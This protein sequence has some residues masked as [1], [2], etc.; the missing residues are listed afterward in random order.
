MTKAHRTG[1]ETGQAPLDYYQGLNTKVFDLV[2][3]GSKRILEV[4]CAKGRL[5]AAIKAR[6]QCARYVGIELFEEAGQEAEKRLDKVFVADVERFDWNRLAGET[7][8]CVIFADVLEHLADP[9]PVL[10]QV[11]KLLAPGGSVV[12]CIPNVAHWSVLTGLIRG[13]WTYTETGVMD[14]THLRFFTYPSFQALLKEC[15]LESVVEDRWYTEIEP[16]ESLFPFLHSLQVDPR[17]F[18]NRATT[19]QFII[20]AQPV[21]AK[22]SAPSADW[23]AAGVPVPADQDSVAIVI[24]ACN[25]TKLT[26]ACLDSIAGSGGSGF[27]V[28]VVDDATCDGTEQLIA[29]ARKSQPWLHTLRL[30]KSVGL[31][32]A[33]NRGAEAT[34][35]GTLVFLDG[36]SL[37][38]PGWLAGML[39]LIRKERVGA[40]APKLVHPDGTLSHVG[41]VFTPDA[42]PVFQYRSAPEADPLANRVKEYPALTGACLM[43]KR[44]VFQEIGGFSG[45]DPT[46]YS[47]LDL[48][49]KMRAKGHR[50]LYQPASKVIYAREGNS[51][52][53]RMTENESALARVLFIQ[54]W[55]DVM[56][57]ELQEESRFYASGRDF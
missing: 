45:E 7:F 4:G 57:K 55:K 33:R 16:P 1:P 8:D 51:G 21:G 13:E 35:A 36:N 49:F 41:I 37:V 10:R 47:D 25:L 53:I 54:R 15:G 2:P 27:Q 5:G 3:I 12:C 48:S 6:N 34:E 31:A 26:R 18:A 20:R 39:E 22:L 17:A 42:H 9:A 50:I 11:V 56:L 29:E 30:E 23:K 28:I 24:A 14:R 46:L 52:A 32:M 38:T 43:I 40:V 19:I 44:T